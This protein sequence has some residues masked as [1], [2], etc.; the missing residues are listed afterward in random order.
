MSN[1]LC[2]IENW[3]TGGKTL[4]CL[5]S[6]EINE[7]QGQATQEQL[8]LDPL[9]Q[10]AV[11]AAG[12]DPDTGTFISPQYQQAFESKFPGLSPSDFISQTQA[13]VDAANPSELSL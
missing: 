2:S 7:A 5:A 4:C 3:L 8:A 9:A 6:C 10:D 1:L 13:A 11:R 12:I